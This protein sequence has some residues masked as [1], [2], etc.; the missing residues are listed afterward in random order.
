MS[1]QN[2][3]SNKKDIISIIYHQRNDSPKHFEI[4]RSRVY[5]FFIGLPTLTLLALVIGAIG[6]V[7]SSPFHLLS[8][9]KTASKNRADVSLQTVFAQI[10][11]RLRRVGHW[12]QPARGLVYT[13]VGGL[14]R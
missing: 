4:K 14:R 12:V 6:L 9:Y 5:L 7:N 13:D 11:D 10:E 1:D 3:D 8:N 2:K